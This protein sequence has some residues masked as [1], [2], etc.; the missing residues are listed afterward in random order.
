VVAP[1]GE[2]SRELRVTTH[3]QRQCPY[4]PGT[5]PLPVSKVSRARLTGTGSGDSPVTIRSMQSDGSGPRS[6]QE[7]PLASQQGTG[8]GKD[9][10]A[11]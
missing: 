9:L 6:A 10:P 11:P 4:Q 7:V 2:T 1:R 3:R 8:L 5:L